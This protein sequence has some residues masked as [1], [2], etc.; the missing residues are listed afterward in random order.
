MCNWISGNGWQVAVMNMTD[1]QLLGA[2]A[3]AAVGGG[4]SPWNVLGCLD[5]LYETAKRRG[6]FGG[7]GAWILKRHTRS[8]WKKRDND[9]TNYVPS[10]KAPWLVRYIIKNNLSKNKGR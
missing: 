8:L 7:V 3:Y 5:E 4:W 2:I 1:D 6:L 9:K 10:G